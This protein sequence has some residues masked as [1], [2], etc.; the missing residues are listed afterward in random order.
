MSEEVVEE[1]AE[2]VNTDNELKVND[3]LAA[4]SL[5]PSRMLASKESTKSTKSR[6]GT[7]NS[8]LSTRKGKIRVSKNSKSVQSIVK[9][10]SCVVMIIVALTANH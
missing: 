1:S 2:E 8:T 3:G 9:L 7:G 4:A 10:F 5:A 6:I